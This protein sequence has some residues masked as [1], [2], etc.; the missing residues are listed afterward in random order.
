MI[1]TNKPFGLSYYKAAAANTPRPWDIWVVTTNAVVKNKG[2]VYELVMGA[3]TAKLAASKD[4]SLPNFIFNQLARLGHNKNIT[5]YGG[6][7]TD[8]YFLML[9]KENTAILQTKRH[10]KDPT[11]IDLLQTSIKM[12]TLVAKTMPTVI[13]HMPRPGC[14][15]GGL[16]WNTTVKKLCESLPD[17][18]YI[19]D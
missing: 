6:I 18:V 9:P 3:G 7:L 10:F 15:M 17:N 13:F 19:Y 8:Y 4:P 11:P 1:L 5:G 16:D 12:M 2:G 14:G